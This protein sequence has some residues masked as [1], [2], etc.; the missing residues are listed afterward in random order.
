VNQATTWRGRRDADPRRAHG[1]RRPHRGERADCTRQ[2]TGDAGGAGLRPGALRGGDVPRGAERREHRRHGRR[3]VG[4]DGAEESP[5][6][7]RSVFAPALDSR[8]PVR[9]LAVHTSPPIMR[10][11]EIINK[12]SHNL[13]AEQVL[14]TVGRV[15]VGEGSVEGGRRAL[16]HM[17]RRRATPARARSRLRRLRPVRAE[18]VERAGP[19]QPAGVMAESPMWDA[20][21]ET[22]PEAGT[23]R[24]APHA[25]DG[26]GR[27]PAGEDRHHRPGLRCRAT[28]ALRTANA[29]PSPSSATTC[30]PRGMAK[31][32]EDAIGARLAAPERHPGHRTSVGQDPGGAHQH[33]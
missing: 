24:P 5:V 3:A 19:G 12:R 29:S 27:Q 15:A 33:A 14:R 1:L 6:T 25:P 23:R 10:V 9:V 31:R 16:E 28:S 17:M 18:P 32:I 22:L 11:L 26:R 20:Y 2:R 7:G 13:M 30:R 4:A 8:E 21:W